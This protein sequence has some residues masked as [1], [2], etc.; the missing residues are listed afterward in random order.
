M[1]CFHLQFFFDVN[2]ILTSI[3]I[4]DLNRLW[5]QSGTSQAAISGAAL[6]ISLQISNS[7]SCGISRQIFA[8]PLH[9]E[10]AEVTL[11]EDI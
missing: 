8:E 9:Y 1:G 6:N 10:I 5:L 4:Q 7:A 3:K 11:S 2:V